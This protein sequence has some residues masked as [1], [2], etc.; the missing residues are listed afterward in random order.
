[1][2]EL[3]QVPTEFSTQ[4]APIP[5]SLQ[6]VSPKAQAPSAT[7]PYPPST[8]NSPTAPVPES[9]ASPSPTSVSSS[10]AHQETAPES[11]YTPANPLLFPTKPEEVKIQG[12]QPITLKQV[13]ELAERNN[14]DLEVSRLKVNQARASLR[15]AQAALWP[16]LDLQGTLTRS[17]SASS[18]ISIRSQ[19][20]DYQRN[21]NSNPFLQAPT[22]TSAPVSTSL[23]GAIRLNY[24]VFTSGLRSAQIDA[25]AKNVRAAELGL[26]QQR[27][28][29][30][31]SATNAYYTLQNSDEQVRI[32]QA[33][34]RSSEQSLRDSEAQERAGIGTRFDV[35]RSQV[36]LANNQKLL[37]DA[38]ANQET[39]RRQLAQLLSLPEYAEPVAADPVEK[40]GDW[41]LSLEDSII[42]AYKNRAE[43]EQ[44]LVQREISED[45]RK[46][47]L[48]ALGPTLSLQA[49]YDLLKIFEQP[50]TGFSDGYSFSA[51]ASWRLFDGGKAHAQAQQ[52][53]INKQI[54]EANFAK[55]RNTVRLDVETAYAKLISNKS[56]IA[57]TELAVQQATEALRLANLRF[58]AGVG[59]QSDVINAQSDLTLAQGNRVS[60]ILGYNQALAELQRAVSNIGG[61]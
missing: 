25:A 14:R 59:T 10:S 54:A 30:L 1:M 46:A 2:F 19:I 48:S 27:E 58:N 60:A 13:L 36:Q 53:E 18:E 11:L 31:L 6:Q 49:S 33:A 44:Q 9:P 50:V 29:V 39:S 41:K 15:E 32:Y 12:A 4:T 47:A 7:T 34:V 45:Q 21:K 5:S 22:Q 40:A 56:S 16:T 51:V 24:D 57:S 20:I 52:Q 23:D 26:E 35:L 28:D 43:L 61:D 38:K 37:A 8:D 3:A 55:A 17:S 42:A